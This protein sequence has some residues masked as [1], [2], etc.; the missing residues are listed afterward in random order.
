VTTPQYDSC[1]A[2]IQKCG[3]ADPAEIFTCEEKC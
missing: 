1:K 3:G 2:C